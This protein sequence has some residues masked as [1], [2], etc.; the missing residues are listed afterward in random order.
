[1]TTLR[2]NSW[3]V[4]QAY[5]RESTEPERMYIE[6][7]IEKNDPDVVFLAEVTT[8]PAI[9]ES[10]SDGFEKRLGYTVI[11]AVR[12]TDSEQDIFMKRNG[13]KVLNIL[14]HR[15][16]PDL[17]VTAV[18]L[19]GRSMFEAIYGGGLPLAFTHLDSWLASNRHRSVQQ[20]LNRYGDKPSDQP[21]IVAG[22]LNSMPAA[23]RS[24][25]LSVL[26]SAPLHQLTQTA[27]NLGALPE[28]LRRPINIV[29]RL[30]EAATD[31]VFE[32][33]EQ[34]GV[35]NLSVGDIRPTFDG[36]S[37]HRLGRHVRLPLDHV[38]GRG[39][40]SSYQAGPVKVTET[41]HSLGL[42]HYRQAVDIE[43]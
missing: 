39:N 34:A 42:D 2:I 8:D 31:D 19:A 32:M 25:A 13:V 24:P 30:A 20:L 26:R 29:R 38:L 17:E 11:S 28:K 14:A 1:M 15:D 6:H 21:L 7:Q 43:V 10:F 41:P 12:A 16:L 37:A 4:G 22:D 27:A 35:V 3:N 18:D 5:S 33:F 40:G 9:P 23:A 36:R